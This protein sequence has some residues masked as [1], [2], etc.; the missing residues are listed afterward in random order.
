MLIKLNVLVWFIY[1]LLFLLIPAT[2]AQFLL[3]AAPS[4]ASAL[5]DMR[6]MLGGMGLAIAYVMYTLEKRSSL[7]VIL[8]LTLGMA[9][10]RI[11]G[12]IIDGGNVTMYILLALELLVVALAQK[13]LS[14][15][16]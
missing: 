11:A 8:F 16:I 5:T 6:A 3:D 10:G 1:G 2:I 4:T 9:L 13:Q 14:G 7:Q 12:L 15:S